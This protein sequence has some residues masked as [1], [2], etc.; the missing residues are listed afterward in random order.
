MLR[1]LAIAALLVAAG[2][3]PL[4]TEQVRI[5]RLV[6]PALHAD[7]TMIRE[8]GAAALAAGRGVRHPYEAIEPGNPPP[9]GA[10]WAVCPLGGNPPPPS[11]LPLV[12][13]RTHPG[14]P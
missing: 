10:P 2:C 12:G 9:T 7:G 13:G 14:P 11:P 5:C 8:T 1:L 3:A 4:D 6:L